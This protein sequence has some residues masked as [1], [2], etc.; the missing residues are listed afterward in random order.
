[1]LAIFLSKISVN[2]QGRLPRTRYICD[3]G[4]SAK[5]AQAPG[6]NTGRPNES[7]AAG[8]LAALRLAHL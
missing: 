6:V 5:I 8:E 3:A 4:R 2:E 7:S 1:M